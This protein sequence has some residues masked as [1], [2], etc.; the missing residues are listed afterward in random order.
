MAGAGPLTWDAMLAALIG[1]LG[2][3]VDVAVYMPERGFM[4]GLV[5]NFSGTLR[6]AD[7]LTIHSLEGNAEERLFFFFDEDEDTGFFLLKSAFSGAEQ[8]GGVLDVHMG[9]VSV[10]IT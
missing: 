2:Q 8:E 7:D 9:G 4:G 6:A 10:Q 1:K 3:D 5:A